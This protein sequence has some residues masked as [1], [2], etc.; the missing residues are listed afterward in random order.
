VSA[1]EG[2]P[3]QIRTAPAN[4]KKPPVPT[5]ATHRMGRPPKPGPKPVRKTDVTLTKGLIEET[6]VAARKLGVSILEYGRLAVKAF[7]KFLME[8]PDAVVPMPV[9]CEACMRPY[10]AQRSKDGKGRIRAQV[11]F[12]DDTTE[13]MNFVADNYYHG[14]Y[15]RAFEASILHYMGK[16]LD[17]SAL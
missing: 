9:R 7:A 8:H 4:T 11:H 13:C 14:T 17:G 16:P 3:R 2:K 5:H 15:S 12:D 1:I 10:V 6:K